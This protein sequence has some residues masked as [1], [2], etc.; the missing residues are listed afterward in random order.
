MGSGMGNM[1]DQM[2]GGSG[3]MVFGWLGMLLGIVL[4]VSLIVLV[5]VAIARLR[6]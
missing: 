3:M 1:M 6:R 2:M 4:L 5:W